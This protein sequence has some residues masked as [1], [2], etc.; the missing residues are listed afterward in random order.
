[1]DFEHRSA[2]KS[3]VLVNFIADWT[4]AACDT[5]AQ[6]E[7]PIWIMHCDRAWGTNGAVIA[8]ILTPPKG[9]KLRYAA[10]WSFSQPTT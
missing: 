9:P 5:T 10:S 2:I 6:F 3:Q 8:T 7:E 1:V 4:P